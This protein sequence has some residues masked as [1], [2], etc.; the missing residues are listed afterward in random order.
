MIAL[1][2]PIRLLILVLLVVLAIYLLRR[3][4]PRVLAD[5]RLR[6]LLS[7]VGL[8]MLRVY[9]IRSAL[10]FLWRLLRTLRFFR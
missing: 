6:Y 2:F 5:P 10:P 3:I 8:Q 7:G 1:A 9:L 4:L